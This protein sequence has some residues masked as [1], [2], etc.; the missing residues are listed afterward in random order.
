MTNTMPKIN[1]EDIVVGQK[2]MCRNIRSGD[3]S[4]LDDMIVVKAIELPFIAVQIVER[5]CGIWSDTDVRPFMM[6][7]DE[8]EFYQPSEEFL[9]IAFARYFEPTHAVSNTEVH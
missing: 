9:R 3:R 8:Y 1:V 4:F 2:L 6:L 7:Q 5:N